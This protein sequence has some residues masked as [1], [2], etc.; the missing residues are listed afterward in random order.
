MSGRLADIFGRQ[1]VL[2]V[3]IVLFAAGSAVTGAADTMGKIIIGRSKS[4]LGCTRCPCVRR[5]L[6]DH[7]LRAAIQGV[8]SGA[9]QVL[10]AIVTADLIPL[11][12]RGFFQSITGA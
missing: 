1:R 8:G 9:I 10:V 12:E 2:L 3:A 7:G 6:M 4:A 5:T 11:K